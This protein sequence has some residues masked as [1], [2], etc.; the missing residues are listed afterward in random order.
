[1]TQGIFDPFG[2]GWTSKYTG[3]SVRPGCGSSS[4]VCPTPVLATA[5]SYGEGEGEGEA[6]RLH[7]CGPAVHG[8]CGILQNEPS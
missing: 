6:I 4:R 1:V 3:R 2:Q 7:D 8:A 5:M